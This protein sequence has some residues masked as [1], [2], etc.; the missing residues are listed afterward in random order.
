MSSEEDPLLPRNKGAPEIHYGSVADNSY[1]QQGQEVD[2]KG[3]QLSDSRSSPLRAFFTLFTI[4][5]SFALLITF[6]TPDGI[7]IP[8][9]KDP[10]RT[11]PRSLEARVN[12]ILSENPLIGITRTFRS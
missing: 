3:T 11:E 6:L 2:D 5:V 4:V 10:F 1:E 12:K 8:S 7:H 9:W